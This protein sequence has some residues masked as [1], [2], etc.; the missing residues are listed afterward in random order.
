[1]VL[2]SSHHVLV[3]GVHADTQRLMLQ[4]RQLAGS[5]ST[6]DAEEHKEQDPEHRPRP[7]ELVPGPLRGTG[8]GGRLC[9]ENRT[10]REDFINYNRLCSK[11]NCSGK[12][13]NPPLQLPFVVNFHHL[14]L[15]D[16]LR[17]GFNCLG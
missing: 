7:R 15:I 10:Q 17:A 9:R 12:I 8:A 4:L 1:M 13:L 14:A 11:T 16:E 3:E 5:Q 6:E 2:Q